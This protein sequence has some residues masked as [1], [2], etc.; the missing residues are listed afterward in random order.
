MTSK[1]EGADF[2][3]CEWPS[4]SAKNG[5]VKCWNCKGVLKCEMCEDKQ[6]AV[7]IHGAY[8]VCKEHEYIAVANT[9]NRG[10]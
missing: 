1:R 5:F 3:D 6:P 4:F 2:C 10:W 8:V 9:A 7:L